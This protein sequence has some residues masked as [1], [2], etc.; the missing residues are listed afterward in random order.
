[1]KLK[2]PWCFTG[3]ELGNAGADSDDAADNFMARHAGINCV[4][5]FIPG[6]VKVRVADP[7][8]KYFDFNIQR[9]EFAPGNPNGSQ[10]GTRALRCI[11]LDFG[12][13][14]GFS[15]TPIKSPS[16]A[17]RANPLA[18]HATGKM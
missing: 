17:K 1:M 9:P 18:K 13:S 2:L 4:V 11:S 7:A 8:V 5:P 16:L 15:I 10:R 12:S 14:H 6:L 3:P